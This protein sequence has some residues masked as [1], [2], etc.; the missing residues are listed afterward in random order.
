MG[1]SKSRHTPRKGEE[2]KKEVTSSSPRPKEKLAE[3][4]P[5]EAKQAEREGEKP[6]DLRSGADTAKH[7]QQPSASSKEKPDAKQ[8]STRKKSV[9]PQI[10]ITRA[11]N[12][13]LSSF[14]SSGSEEQRTIREHT[15]WGLYHRHRNPS[16][17]DAYNARTKQ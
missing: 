14:G 13:T 9:I 7:Q 16:T 17:V 12:E 11:S 1:I 5:Q 15:T 3:K 8:K 10:I 2:E 6:A 4:H